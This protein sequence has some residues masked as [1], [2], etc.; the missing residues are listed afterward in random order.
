MAEA[1]ALPPEKL[2]GCLQKDVPM[3]APRAADVSLDSSK[4]F[5]LGY[6]PLSLREE[7]EVLRGQ[8]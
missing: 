4:A 7:L 8:V 1:L 5:G 3:S 6:Q 2:K